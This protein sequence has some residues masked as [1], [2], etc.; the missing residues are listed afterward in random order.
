MNKIKVIKPRFIGSKED[1]NKFLSGFCRN[2]VQ[3]IT[4]KYKIQV[5]KCEHC[6]AI[7]KQ[8]DA[9]HIHGNERKTIID[10]A[11]EEF[12]HGDYVDVDLNK[13]ESQFIDAHKPIERIIKILCKDCH[14]IY[15]KKIY[16]SVKPKKINCYDN[17]LRANKKTV[18]G[19][20][21]GQYVKNRMFFLLNNN[22]LTLSTISDL[23]NKDYC[24]Q[25]F[26]IGHPLLINN[27]RLIKD[28][29]GIS[30]YYKDEVIEGYWLCSQWFES[31]WDSFLSWEK[32][33]NK[34]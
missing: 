22:K 16:N 24:K 3:K 19:M 7:D 26:K 5:G 25:I 12:G 27:K 10:S 31:Q 13:F 14:K 33:I 15:D 28:S 9:A 34:H 20:K 4:R 11:L 17:Q 23:Q 32:S 30:R 18:N 1:F 29:K 8:L 6:G 21:I 2:L